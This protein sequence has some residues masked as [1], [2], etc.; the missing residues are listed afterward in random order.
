MDD[1]TRHQIRRT[2]LVELFAAD[3]RQIAPKAT[4]LILLL[5]EERQKRVRSYG[6]SRDAQRCLAAGLLA[7]RRFCERARNAHFEHG[8]RGKPFFCRMFA[9]QPDAPREITLCSRSPGYCGRRFG[10]DS[11]HQLEPGIRTVLSTKRARFL[12]QSSEPQTMFFT[13]WTLKESYLKALGH[14]FSVSPRSFC[15]LPEGSGAV[16][17]SDAGFR[18]Q[19]FSVFPGYCLSVCCREEEIASNVVL[20]E[21]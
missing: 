7:L 11:R 13:I 21:F 17:E 10:A 15:V 3:I 14:G 12:E 9:V 18:F 4:M 5:D 1:K 8:K 20:K 16:L 2:I 6:S 19:S